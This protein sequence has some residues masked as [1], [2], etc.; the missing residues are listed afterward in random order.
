M[1][2]SIDNLQ[3]STKRSRGTEEEYI[4]KKKSRVMPDKVDYI[5]DKEFSQTSY[6]VSAVTNISDF[7]TITTKSK[8]IENKR[9]SKLMW[10]ETC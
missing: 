7:Q 6:E 3:L 9:Q 1:S 8:V 2:V 4:I 10:E 5:H